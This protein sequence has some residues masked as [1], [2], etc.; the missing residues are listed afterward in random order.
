[1]IAPADP[2]L[3]AFREAGADR[4]SVHPEAGPH[5]DRSVQHI[6]ELGAKAG[7]VLN[8]STPPEAIEWMLDDVDLVLVMTVNPGF[9]GQSFIASQL[10]KI[11]RLREMIDASGRD[12]VL[13]VDGGVTPE[14]ARAL[15]RRRRHGPGRR[16]RRLR[17]RSQPLRRQHPRPEGRL[18]RAGGQGGGR[19]LRRPRLG[20]WSRGADGR[21]RR[22]G[23]AR[24]ARLAACISPAS[25]AGRRRRLGRRLAQRRAAGGPDHGRDAILGG[26]FTL[27]R[28][29]PDRR[30]GR[31]RS[32]EPRPAPAAASPLALHRFDWLARPDG[33]R[34][35]GAARGAAP[36]LGLA[37][38]V[39]ALEPLRLGARPS[40]S[41]GCSTWPAPAR[42]LA[43]LAREGRARPWPRAWRARRGICFRLAQ[44]TAPR[45][46]AVRRGRRRRAR[47]WP[48]RPASACSRAPARG[49]TP[50]LA[51]TVGA[52][53]G[54]ASR[55]PEAGLEL[56]FDLLRAGGRLAQRGAPAPTSLL[57][58]HRP[59]YRRPCAFF[60]LSDGRLPALQGG[61]DQ[62]SAR[63]SPPRW[64]T[65]A[66]DRS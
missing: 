21:D 60:T 34:R 11:E 5:L 63:G 57:A 31:R 27:G 66:A 59:A 61:E 55:S 41:G 18:S 13:E 43:A 6:R 45:R 33:G 15:P 30:R 19:R 10:R 1:M 8:P 7:V 20:L 37:A 49:W 53:G 14:T 56:L 16:H 48:A 54:H 52:D 58:R 12:I 23:R 36:D 44:D 9:G 40:W 42:D 24:V 39:R 2:Y 46:R 22:P 62:R 35:G 25:S 26:V 32:L 17:G 64:R 50:R 29:D 28:R 38:R 47:P 3:E 4:I 65:T 51:R